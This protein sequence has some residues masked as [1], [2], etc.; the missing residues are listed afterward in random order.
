[1]GVLVACCFLIGLAPLLVAPIVGQGVSAWAPG[2]KDAGPASPRWPRWAGSRSWACVLIGGLARG[3]RGAVAAAPAQRRGRRA[4]PGAA[5]TSPRRRGCSTPRPPSPRCWSG[6]SAG[7]CARASTQPKDLPLFPQKTAFHSEV[8]D[9]VLDEA[10]LPAFR[11]GA[12][13]FS[14]FRVFQQGSIQT[15]L[16]YI[17]IALIALLLWR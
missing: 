11:F 9:T 4:P 12:W 8:P 10:V 2:L 16:L 7:R 6:C 5:A 1:M 3:W 13:L 14:W 17:F 15:Y